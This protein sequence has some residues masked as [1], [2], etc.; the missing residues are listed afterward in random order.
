MIDATATDAQRRAAIA[1]QVTLARATRAV[2]DAQIDDILA[3]ASWPGGQLCVDRAMAVMDM[4]QLATDPDTAKPNI[5]AI[6]EAAGIRDP[7]PEGAA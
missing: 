2:L 4:I 3:L 7:L 5:D 6:L 1:R